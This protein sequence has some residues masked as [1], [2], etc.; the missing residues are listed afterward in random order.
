MVLFWWPCKQLCNFSN[1]NCNR[2]LILGLILRSCV[3][4]CCV[5]GNLIGISWKKKAPLCCGWT[6]CNKVSCYLV[7]ASKKCK[8]EKEA[9]L[10]F[11][12][13]IKHNLS[14][15]L[16]F[17]LKSYN[18]QTGQHVSW[19]KSIQAIW[20]LGRDCLAVCTR[21][22]SLFCSILISR[23]LVAI[24]WECAPDSTMQP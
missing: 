13:S 1:A 12:Y 22:L 8:K 21:S 11:V 16:I 18:L 9:D 23:Q 17:K 10:L 24:L 2:W 19:P 4:L 15:L 7:Y 20:L 6:K 14:S 5:C 3:M